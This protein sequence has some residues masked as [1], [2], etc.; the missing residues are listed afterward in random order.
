MER[1][2]EDYQEAGSVRLGYLIGRALISISDFVKR[3]IATLVEGTR[4]GK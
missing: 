2:I 1:F 3:A 4:W